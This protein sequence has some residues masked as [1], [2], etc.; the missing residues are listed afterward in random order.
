MPL[1]RT[2]ISVVEPLYQSLKLYWDQCPDDVQSSYGNE[3]LEDFK[4][5][6]D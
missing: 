2:N 6:I 5:T 4:V 3:Y 1:D